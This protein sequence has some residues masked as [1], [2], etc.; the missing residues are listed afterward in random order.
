MRNGVMHVYKFVAV[1]KMSFLSSIF[2]KITKHVEFPPVLDLAPFCASKVKL[3]K[4][5]QRHQKKM[6]YSLYGI[7]EHS[8]GMAGESIDTFQKVSNFIQFHIPQVVTM[9][10]T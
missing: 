4:N 9:L 6:L 5:V 2:R 3:L 10:H 8:G 1:F 7:V